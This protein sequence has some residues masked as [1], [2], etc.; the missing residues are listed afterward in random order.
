MA[1]IKLDKAKE[2]LGISL[3]DNTKDTQVEDAILA[4]ESQIEGFCQR[5]FKLG[6]YVY[7]DLRKGLTIFLQNYPVSAVNKILVDDVEK[8]PSYKLT[9]SGILIFTGSL[10]NWGTELNEIIEVQYTGGYSS[11]PDDLMSAGLGVMASNY[12][13]AQM[14]QNVGPLKFERIEGSVSFSYGDPLSHRDPELMH[15]SKWMSI[16]NNYV[17]DT[18]MVHS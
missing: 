17:A 10:D 2:K 16:L 7:R 14:D 15:L 9:P 13:D 8:T 12:A 4:A 5:K 18:R 1:W 6:Q 3:S 11:I